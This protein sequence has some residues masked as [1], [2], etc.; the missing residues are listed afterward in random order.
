MLQIIAQSYIGPSLRLI[1]WSSI[2]V[3]NTCIFYLTHETDTNNYCKIATSKQKKTIELV[4]NS[5]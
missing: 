3:L 4:H 5:A 1:T 2:Y